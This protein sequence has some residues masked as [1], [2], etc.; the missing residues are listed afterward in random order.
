M[1]LHL[2]IPPDLCIQR[3]QGRTDH[4]TLNGSNVV[5]VIHRYDIAYM[6]RILAMQLPALPL[7]IIAH[8]ANYFA[9]HSASHPPSKQCAANNLDPCLN[10]MFQIT[11]LHLQLLIAPAC[12]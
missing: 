8:C 4:P 2:D 11:A 1:G 10:T 12:L 9:A 5:D 6:T 7:H 3:A